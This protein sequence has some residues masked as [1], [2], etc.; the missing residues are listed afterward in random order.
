MEKSEVGGGVSGK[1][2]SVRASENADDGDRRGSEGVRGEG[3]GKGGI[4]FW[5]TSRVGETGGG[6]S[7]RGNAFSAG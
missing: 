2:R 1:I 3:E 7:G 4:A 5:I 6:K